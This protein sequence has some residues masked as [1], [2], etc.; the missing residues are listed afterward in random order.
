MPDPQLDPEVDQSNPGKVINYNTAVAFEAEF[1]TLLQQGNGETNTVEKVR[2][3]IQLFYISG[4][5]THAATL[6]SAA[7]A[8]GE[9]I[10]IA[11]ELLQLLVTALPDVIAALAAATPLIE[12]A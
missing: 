6:S 12:R 10:G 1:F 8:Q 5:H 9:S 4:A 3:A 2:A 7:I 11:A